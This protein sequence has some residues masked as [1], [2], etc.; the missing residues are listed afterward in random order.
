[1]QPKYLRASKKQLDYIAN[2]CGQLDILN[3][4]IYT[5]YSLGNA[6]KLINKLKR[7]I[8]NKR[9][10]DRQTKLFWYNRFCTPLVNGGVTER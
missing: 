8:E 7:K 9:N 4:T 3:P 6:A 2:L 1:M 10:R 5:K